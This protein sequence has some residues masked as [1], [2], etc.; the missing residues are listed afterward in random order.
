M[1]IRLAKVEDIEVI[2]GFDHVAT[3]QKSRR[4]FIKR[5]ILKKR[6]YVAISKEELVGYTVL[7]YSFFE[8]GFVSMLYIKENFRRKGIGTKLMGYIDTKCNTE[9]LFTSTNQSNMPMQELLEKLNFVRSGIIH[10][11]DPDDPELIYFKKIL[12]R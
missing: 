11:L 12:L 9:K 6:C 10:N 3:T 4:E 5:A 8:C 1:R 7:E 2:I